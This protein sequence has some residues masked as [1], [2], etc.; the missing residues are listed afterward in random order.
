MKTQIIQLEH[1]DDAT[2]TRDKMGWSQTGRI[3][4]VW[5]RK[6][7]ILTRQIDL[8][9]LLRHAQ[10]LG[11]Q[12][13]LATT[14]P[15][16]KFNAN[17]IGL[18]VFTTVRQAQ[19]ARW[20]RPQRAQTQPSILDPEKVSKEKTEFDHLVHPQDQLRE[21]PLT[22][23]ITLF[24]IAIFAVLCIAAVLFPSAEVKLD[25]KPQTQ[26]ITL[27]VLAKDGV[28]QVMV[29]GI[30]PIHWVNFTVDGEAHQVSSGVTHIPQDYAV[31]TVIFTNLT[32]HQIVVPKGT[33]VS[34]QNLDLSYT[35][36]QSI[37][38]PAGPGQTAS[39]RITA[40]EPGEKGNIGV[41]AIQNVEGTL[42][43][44]MTVTN[45]EALVGGTDV[46]S[47]APSAKDY[48]DLQAVL[49]KNLTD[50]ATLIWESKL[51]PGDQALDNE[52]RFIR[53]IDEVFTPAESQPASELFLNLVL[54]YKMPVVSKEDLASL[55]RTILD[56]NLPDGY[57]IIPNTETIESLSSPVWLDDATARWQIKASRMIQPIPNENEAASLI[58]GLSPRSALTKLG[59][60]VDLASTPIILRHPTWWPL[61]PFL[62]FRIELQE[63]TS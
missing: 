23:R 4:L 54:E 58:A 51:S 20:K 1:H 44:D 21:L 10:M 42:G 27:S 47:P 6:G 22:A 3:L 34:T 49:I 29:T 31:G 61:L 55:T 36:D 53:K 26:Q 13:A 30:V 25:P 46:L 35:T 32:D 41:G 2:S 24:S 45:P 17:Q 63:N 15:E 56:A 19:F 18:S 59:E 38:I 14:D 62:P 5:P 43:L 39:T 9:L 50:E 8:I 48:S 60:Q 57:R 33:V 7:R 28:E 52:P 12:L 11:V 16:V 37:T 40:K